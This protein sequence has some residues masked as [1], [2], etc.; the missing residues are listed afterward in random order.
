MSSEGERMSTWEKNCPR[1]MGFQDFFRKYSKLFPEKVERY[2]KN[3]W[4]L[5]QDLTYNG[6]KIANG[7]YTHP[8]MF[9]LFLLK[10]GVWKNPHGQELQKT[11][12]NIASNNIETIELVFSEALAI[13]RNY[14][15]D[16]QEVSEDADRKLID[17]FGSLRGFGKETGSRKMV[18]AILRFLD[19][20]KYGTVDYR[21]WIILSNTEHQFLKEPLLKPLANTIEESKNIEIDSTKYVVYLRVIRTLAKFHGTTPADIDMALFAYSDE[22]ISLGKKYIPILT[23]TESKEKT[24]RMMEVIQEVVD[25]VRSLGLH[26]H[27]NILLSRIEPLSRRGDYEGIYLYCRRAISGKSHIDEMIEKRGGKS[28]RKMFSKIEK[29]YQNR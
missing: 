16:N 27:A 22:I 4:A 3:H 15:K 7:T 1:R 2:A 11:I 28:L 12:I 25:S 8:S 24:L 9:T 17:A 5:T 20:A 21:N 26:R 13:Y 6:Q 18:S 23:N 14:I 19:P 10:V 29:I